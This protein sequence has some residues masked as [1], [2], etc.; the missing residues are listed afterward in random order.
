MFAPA[1]DT[2]AAVKAWLV[3]S[4][5]AEARITHSDNKGWL[6][7]DA[8]AGEAEDLL[9]TEYHVYEHASYGA[10]ATACEQCVSRRFDF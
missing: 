3:S 5:I 7:F 9:H 6:A 4:G 10:T 1:D 2:V 8:T